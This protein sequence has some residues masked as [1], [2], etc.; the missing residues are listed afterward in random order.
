MEYRWT[1]DVYVNPTSE[2]MLI[3][4]TTLVILLVIGGVV[5]FLHMREKVR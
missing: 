2:T 1:L 4:M 5:V 3:V